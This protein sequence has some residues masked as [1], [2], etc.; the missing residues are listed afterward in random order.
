MV[1]Q[2]RQHRPGVRR[3]PGQRVQRVQQLGLPRGRLRLQHRQR[4]IDQR[5]AGARPE[6]ARRLP[7]LLRERRRRS[8]QLALERS[9]IQLRR[10]QQATEQRARGVGTA[11][12]LPQRCR[13]AVKQ[14]G[15][16]AKPRHIRV[17]HKSRQRVR[18]HGARLR[19]RC[20]RGH[21]FCGGRRGLR[22]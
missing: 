5:Q 12:R 21:R 13:N 6:P 22:R 4:E 15:G 20:L 10:R 9:R 2:Q 14:R 7:V 1:P 3:I 17:A 18:R 16:V 8:A 11:R 19:G